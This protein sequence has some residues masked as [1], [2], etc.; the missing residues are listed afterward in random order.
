MEVPFAKCHVSRYSGTKRQKVQSVCTFSYVP[1]LQT[2]Q[3][4]LSNKDIQNELEMSQ[5]VNSP[6]YHDYC[7]GSVW[8]EHKLFPDKQTSIY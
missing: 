7:S 1:L 3:Q 8:S 2:L 4:L 5:T 6:H